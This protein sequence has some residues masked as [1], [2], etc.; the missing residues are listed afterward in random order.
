MARGSARAT[1]G[2]HVG[3]MYG[4]P[5]SWGGGARRG[6]GGSGALALPPLGPRVLRLGPHPAPTGSGAV[7]GCGVL[8][9]RGEA[10]AGCV[11][12]VLVLGRGLVGDGGL[13]MFGEC[14]GEMLGERG[15]EGGRRVLCLQVSI[16]DIQCLLE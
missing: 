14:D 15:G 4:A 7:R 12:G 5:S 2:R 11:V 16:I 13:A 8:L 1:E 10:G 6:C 3:V 9:A